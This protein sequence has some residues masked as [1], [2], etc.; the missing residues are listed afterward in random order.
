MILLHILSYPA[1]AT[2]FVFITLSLG[3]IHLTRT[4]LLTHHHS[5]RRS[6]LPRPTHRGTLSSRETNS[7]KSDKPHH[8][9]LSPHSLHRS[10]TPSSH[11]PRYRFSSHLSPKLQS[12]LASRTPHL[13]LLP[14]LLPPRLS[15]YL[16]PPHSPTN[17][18]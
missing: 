2:A 12:Q 10:T 15:Q 18:T 3:T 1:A 13:L 6:S 14:P 11:P 7:Q 8:T 9:P 16:P 5:S 17:Q 4:T